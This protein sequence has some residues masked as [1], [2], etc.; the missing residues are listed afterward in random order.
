MESYLMLLSKIP[1]VFMIL[2]FKV[3]LILAREHRFGNVKNGRV[4]GAYPVLLLLFSSTP[5]SVKILAKNNILQIG[6]I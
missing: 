1:R 3:V 5:W 6:L 2:L 4:T